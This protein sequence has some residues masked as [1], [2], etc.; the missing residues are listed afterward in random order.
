[1]AIAERAPIETSV[2]TFP[3]ESANQALDHLRRGQVRGAAVLHVS[4]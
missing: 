4:A 3:L 2:E 1:M